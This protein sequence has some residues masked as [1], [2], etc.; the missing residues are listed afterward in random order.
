MVE[1]LGEDLLQ[2]RYRV[3]DERIGVFRVVHVL[4]PTFANDAQVREV[5]VDQA[6]RL[7]A[8]HHPGV[9][10]LVDVQPRSVM[11][12]VVVEDH[13]GPS[14]LDH[15]EHAGP[16]APR[17]AVQALR[18]AL[19]GLQALHEAGFVH[20]DVHP[21][22]L[23]PGPDGGLVITEPSLRWAAG[24]ALSSLTEPA[25]S[26]PEWRRDPSHR[27]VAS[28]IYSIGATLFA[29]LT[30]TAPPD[31]LYDLEASDPTLA[32]V[33]DALRSVIVQCCRLQPA[34]RPKQVRSVIEALGRAS[35]AVGPDPEGA[36]PLVAPEVSLPDPLPTSFPALMPILDQV[37]PAAGFEDES[38]DDSATTQHAT[39]L[40]Y[41]MTP[42]Q[43]DERSEWVAGK[44][45]L[46]PDSLP[47]YVDKES[48]LRQVEE[49]KDEVRRKET[50]T[51]A[52]VKRIGQPSPQ[53]ARRT[54]GK[55][56][57]PDLPASAADDDDNS[58]LTRWVMIG[59]FGGV[60]VALVALLGFA[61][62]LLMA[63]FRITDAREATR[64]SRVQLYQTMADHENIVAS[65]DTNLHRTYASWE[66]VKGEPAR[67]NGALGFLDA[68]ALT[69]RIVERDDPRL[70]QITDAARRF[71]ASR[72]NYRRSLDLW[73][74]EAATF[75]GRTVVSIGMAGLPPEDQS[76]SSAMNR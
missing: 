33:P 29:L 19:A 43:R 69:M 30:G 24:A 6:R 32:A 70:P 9:V 26:S 27:S 15:V 67:I 10:R 36:A 40:P 72:E 14:V 28:D 57:A 49:E 47:I 62:I 18:P 41:T 59:G 55:A 48:V 46:N 16:L 53:P 11:P 58:S 45:R 25:W 21:H 1:A 3:Y 44:P 60:T 2:H 65:M 71:A 12:W 51:P 23:L 50:V 66:E 13:E 63:R 4:T 56:R 61:I 68:F 73:R 8:F 64:V 75:T 38:D 74:A 37:R 54:L 42:A 35:Q 5:F 20:G 39:P 34:T 76:S 17:Q 7:L 22:N 52:G 31:F